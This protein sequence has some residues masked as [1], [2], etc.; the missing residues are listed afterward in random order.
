MWKGELRSN[1][2]GSV[3]RSKFLLL[4][5]LLDYDEV[6][7]VAFA[8]HF[9]CCCQA[10]YTGADDENIGSVCVS[11]IVDGWD[12]VRIRHVAGSEFEEKSCK[13]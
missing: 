13:E 4:G 2:L 1:S 5:F 10:G 3:G 11:A 7:S 8:Y 9:N 6:P 12:G